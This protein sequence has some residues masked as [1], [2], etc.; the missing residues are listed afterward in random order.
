M[1]MNETYAATI[2][3]VIPVLWLVGAVELHQLTKQWAVAASDLERLAKSVK[4]RL[5]AAEAERVLDVFSRALVD[6][7]TQ[8]QAGKLQ[9]R[10]GKLIYNLWLLLVGMM[11]AVEGFTLYWLGAD[12]GPNPGLAWFSLGVTVAGFVAVTGVPAV[13]S[14]IK[15]HRAHK[16]H[17]E[18]LEA[19]VRAV[20]AAPRAP[21][22]AS[23]DPAE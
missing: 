14:L 16:N 8:N 23:A 1:Q 10:P 20:R 3:A 18:H 7:D 21:A 22:A 6:V 13:T 12:G 15:L 5:D 17:K 4:N 2:A 11:M 9:T 19:I